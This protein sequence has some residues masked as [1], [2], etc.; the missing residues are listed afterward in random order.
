M[1][2]NSNKIHEI[3]R[4]TIIIVIIFETRMSL[5]Q[6][7]SFHSINDRRNVINMTSFSETVSNLFVILLVMLRSENLYDS[8]MDILSRR[9][10]FDPRIKT[11]I[12]T[13]QSVWNELNSAVHTQEK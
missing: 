1:F 8:N 13:W 12:F 10:C 11:D 3:L 4:I 5:H 9:H 2:I 7:N 6:W